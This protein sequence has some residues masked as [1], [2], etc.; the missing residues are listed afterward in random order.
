MYQDFEVLALELKLLKTDWLVTG[1]YKP[2]S[3][4]DITSTSE[5]K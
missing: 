3:L 1:T 5:I 2:S 4:N